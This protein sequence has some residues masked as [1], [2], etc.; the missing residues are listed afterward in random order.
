MNSRLL[1]W[2]QVIANIG[3]IGGLILVGIQMQQNER[4]LKIQ[5]L[6]QFNDS[7]A[8]YE[9]A[10]GGEDL[11]KIWAKS[12]ETPEQLTLAEMRAME[13]LLYVPLV[14]WINLYRLHE[15]GISHG[16]EWKVEVGTNAGY[17]YGSEYGRAWWKISRENLEPPFLPDELKDF[18]DQVIETREESIVMYEE[19]QSEIR[20][21]RDSKGT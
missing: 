2:I 3:I 14:Q 9:T 18:I 13:S 5:L 21:N 4:L 12:I 8:A 7:W 10:V 6:N 1:N 16:N 20:K 19:I 17:F 11:A 15:T